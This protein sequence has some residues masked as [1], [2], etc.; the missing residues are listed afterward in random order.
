MPEEKFWKITEFAQKISKDMQDKL[1]DSKGVHY[2]TV[3]KWF[4]NLESKGIHY[5][6]RVAGEKVYDELDLKIGHIIFERR[7]ANWSLDAIFEALPN[8]LELRPVNHEGPSDE[9]QV[10]NETQMFAKLK[11]DLGSEFVK[12]RQSILQ[13][14]E[15]MVEEKTQVIKNQLPPPENKEQKRQAKRDDFV[16]NMRL[17]MQ[18]DKEAA[19][20]WSK[21][22]E[23][24]RMKKA[25]W[26]R[27]EEDLLAREQFIREYKITNMSRIVREAY[28]D[29]NNN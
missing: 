18:L 8:I 26:F 17:S 1:N 5:V 10:V 14:A 25:G 22:P 29:D 12:L 6:N 3:D 16:T 4:K 19:E 24:V 23:S 2:N 11:E 7:R 28:D 9:S 13:E 20:A 15:R 21:Q 27:K